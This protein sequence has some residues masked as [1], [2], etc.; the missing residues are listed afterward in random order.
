MAGVSHVGEKIN[1]NKVKTDYFELNKKLFHG[2]KARVFLTLFSLTP[3]LGTKIVKIF[4]HR[5]ETV[6]VKFVQ[7]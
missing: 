1:G 5:K 2:R 6:E 4:T 7:G 3:R